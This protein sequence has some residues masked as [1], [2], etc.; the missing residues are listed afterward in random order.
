MEEDGNSCFVIAP[1]GDEGSDTRVRADQVFTHI[2]KP[3]VRDLGYKPLRANDIPHPGMITHQIIEHLLNADLVV[4]DLTDGN[5]NVFYELGIR[6]MTR[7]PVVSILEVGQR[8]PFDVNQSRTILLNH[9]DLDS[10]AVCRNQLTVQI[11]S[12]QEN[13]KNY[14]N[15]VSVTVDLEALSESSDPDRQGLAQV[16]SL[17]ESMYLELNTLRTEVAV[18]SS[19]PGRRPPIVRSA[20]DEQVPEHRRPLRPR[21]VAL[22]KL[23]A[24]G[25]KRPDIADELEMSLSEV[26]ELLRSAYFVLGASDRT[27]AVRN[28]ALEYPEHVGEVF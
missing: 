19:F 11:R 5:P 26:S 1:I 27:E 15:P 20:S 7:K 24:E 28:F 10:A 17:L 2:I 12:L 22:M 13:P 23:L 8:I 3:V 25:K 4:A 21:E 9:H 14:F 16:F 6:H 18:I